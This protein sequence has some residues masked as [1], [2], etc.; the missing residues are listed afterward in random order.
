MLFKGIKMD[1]SLLIKKAE[2]GQEEAQEKLAWLYDEGEIVRKSYKKAFYWYK[3]AAI[4]GNPIVFYNLGLCYLGDGTKR[5]YRLA[6]F[7]TKRAALAGYYDAF[8]ALGWHY[9][10]GFGV[11]QN[12]NKAEKWYLAALKEKEDSKAIF[13]LG[14]IAYDKM[15]FDLATKYF[16]KAISKF[17]H[18]L[19]YYFMGKLF[20][21][22]KGIKKDIFQSESLLL[23]ASKLG[24]LK[25]KRL[26]GSN[27]FIK[28]MKT[29]R[30]AVQK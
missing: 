18:P 7:W 10:N 24:I 29:E 8:L 6:F 12:Y 30:R 11:K 25:A 2:A 5:N 15:Q 28:A 4:H 9:L 3:K 27:K 22:G 14:L 20:F 21:E 26:L 13:S 17:N 19:A 23:E 16:S 1:I